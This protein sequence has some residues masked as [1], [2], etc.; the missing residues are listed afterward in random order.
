[1]AAGAPLS[2]TARLLY[3]TKPNAQLKLFGVV[4]AR[5]RDELDGRLVWAS[6]YESDYEATGAT[7]EDAEG[8]SDLLSQSGHRPRS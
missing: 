2:E 7:V 4:L 8:L 1:M 5:L 3:R 6:L